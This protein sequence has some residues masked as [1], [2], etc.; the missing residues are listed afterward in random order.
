MAVCPNCGKELPE[1][2]RFCAYC[3]TTLSGAQPAP[4]S[5]PQPQPAPAP[6]AQPAPNGYNP[7]PVQQPYGN[8]APYGYPEPQGQPYGAPQLP[9]GYPP[10]AAPPRA[11]KNLKNAILGFI[12][13]LLSAAS[14]VVAFI[15][16]NGLK[17]K[18]LDNLDG[19]TDF[20]LGSGT[21]FNVILVYGLCALAVILGFIAVISS[22][23][24]LVHRQ[25]IVLAIIGLLTGLGGVVLAV[26]ALMKAI[27]Y[28]SEMSKR[29][30]VKN[31]AEKV[32]DWITSY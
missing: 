1:G 20:V 16:G 11:E 27:A 28:S 30:K 12:L 24:A 29:N 17:V 10:Y 8:P 15:L 9:Y 32:I 18:P 2:A 7:Q 21:D 23:K 6:V 14:G 19:I 4:A 13:G 26:F 5:T 25:G 22:I 3:G 31:G